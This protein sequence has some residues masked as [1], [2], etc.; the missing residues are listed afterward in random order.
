MY[1]GSIPPGPG[2]PHT[3]CLKTHGPG[4]LASA[5]R[6]PTRSLKFP[7]VRKCTANNL[8]KYKHACF[9]YGH[10]FTLFA[11]MWN[12]IKGPGY[13]L[14][15]C[16]LVPQ[17]TPCV[18]INVINSH[19][20]LLARSLE[21]IIN[22]FVTWSSSLKRH[23]FSDHFTSSICSEQRNFWSLEMWDPTFLFLF[24]SN[25]GKPCQTRS[26]FCRLTFFVRDQ[27]KRAFFN[28]HCLQ[29]VPKEDQVRWF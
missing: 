11:L 25:R 3:H 6:F 1:T 28:H 23:F 16:F 19:A 5:N 13:T 7:D 21:R 9:V 10:L 27:Y 12:Y 29:P 17:H 2:C 24:F 18:L 8:K 20:F 22:A 15:S 26:Y 14:L 4:E